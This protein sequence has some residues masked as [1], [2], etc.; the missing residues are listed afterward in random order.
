MVATQLDKK[1][2]YL[3]KKESN[4]NSLEKIHE[5][6][7]RNNKSIPKTQKGFRSERH[8]VF[9]EEISKIALYSND[10]KRMQ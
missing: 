7:I 2:N 5:E 10:E 6:F 3:E 1:L 4:I 8:N 9:T